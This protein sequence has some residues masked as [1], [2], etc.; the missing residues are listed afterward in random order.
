MASKHQSGI[1][2]RR[3]VFALGALTACAAAIPANGDTVAPVSGGGL[4]LPAR[5]IPIPNDVSAQAQGWLGMMGRV[6]YEQP[7][8]AN[9]HAAWKAK[10]AKDN[11]VLDPYFSS[12]DKVTSHTT[13]V[14]TLNG[15]T[16]YVVTPTNESAARKAHFFI[17]GGGFVLF[18]GRYT[19]FLAKVAA[20][21][22][23]GI[24]YA[25]DYRMPPDHPAPAA[26][27][28]CLAA[29]RAVLERHAPLSVLVSGE[30]A[31]GNLAAALMHKAR[32]AGLPQPAA[33]FLNTPAV[34][35]TGTGD[36]LQTNRDIDVLLKRWGPS[37][38]DLYTAGADSRSPYVSPLYG[39]VSKGF[40]PTYLRSGT[41]D[42]L[43]SDTVRMHAKLRKAGVE[44]ELFVGEAMPHGGFGGRSPEDSDNVADT[45]RWLARY[46]NSEE[47]STDYPR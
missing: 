4:R 29:Y 3:H 13:E 33:L 5:T 26:L 21:Q 19:G 39:D 14:V 18:G 41:R 6:P 10:I 36:T 22:Y 15:V 43:L 44:A 11:S 47:K 30:S 31:G 25:V 27:D 35:L 9:D 46:W 34:D 17:H 32:D 28:D 16:V 38:T 23:G 20:L 8:P 2:N 7:P 40:P 37:Q 42:L 12:L 45:L 24:V 1:L